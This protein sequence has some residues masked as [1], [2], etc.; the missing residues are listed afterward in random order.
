MYTT[1]TGHLIAALL[2]APAATGL[3]GGMLVW[4]VIT[5]PLLRQHGVDETMLVLMIGAIPTFIVAVLVTYV[6]GGPAMLVSWTIA[7]FMKWRSP[8]SMGATLGITGL[9]FAF[10]LFLPERLNFETGIDQGAEVLL[11]TLPCGFAAGFIGGWVIAS[12]GY[13]KVAVVETISSGEA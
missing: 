4:L 6:L 12:L 5:L 1:R 2:I 9:I 13:D 3:I 11:A 8:M 7:H 10:L